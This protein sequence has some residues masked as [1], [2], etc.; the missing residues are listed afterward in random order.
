MKSALLHPVFSPF[1]LVRNPAQRGSS[2]RVISLLVLLAGLVFLGACSEPTS[3]QL[4]DRTPTPLDP[5]DDAEV[6]FSEDSL[7]NFEFTIADSS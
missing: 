7:L 4:R 6:V 2:A 1:E 5:D 3:A